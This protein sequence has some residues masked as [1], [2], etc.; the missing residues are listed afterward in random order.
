VSFLTKKS[1]SLENFGVNF[2]LIISRKKKPT[3]A[4]NIADPIVVDVSTI[5]IP[6]HLPNTKP[7]KISKGIT[8]PKSNTQKIEKIKKKIVRNKKFSFL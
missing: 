7:E 4:Y 6:H 5:N 8:K 3:S 2:C 1:F